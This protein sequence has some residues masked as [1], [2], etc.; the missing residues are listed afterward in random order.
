MELADKPARAL[1]CS[2]FTVSR[3]DFEIVET[4]REPTSSADI[5]VRGFTGHSCPVFLAG[6]KLATGKSPEPAD[7]NVCATETGDRRCPTSTLPGA[8][9]TAHS[10]GS[11][12][13]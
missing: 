10:T 13:C 7:K 6:G 5:P 11:T 3:C 4:S 9:T 2:G 12:S 1:E 8:P